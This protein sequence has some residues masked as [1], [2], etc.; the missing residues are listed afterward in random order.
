MKEEPA[1]VFRDAAFIE[2]AFRLFRKEIK[3][4]TEMFCGELTNLTLKI[5]IKQ[6]L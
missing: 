3:T 2:S 4:D 1:S 5:W 6:L